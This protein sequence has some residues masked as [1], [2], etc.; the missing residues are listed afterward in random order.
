M[1]EK[2]RGMI[3]REK[4]S[5]LKAYILLLLM[6]A[7]TPTDHLWEATAVSAVMCVIIVVVRAVMRYFEEDKDHI[8]LHTAKNVLLVMTSTFLVFSGT[9]MIERFLQ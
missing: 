3:E 5:F 6:I 2:T 9:F 7:L 1:D 4:G 8:V